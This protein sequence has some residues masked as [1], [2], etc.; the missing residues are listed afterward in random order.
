MY[1]VAS[2]LCLASR[3]KHKISPSQANKN[4]EREAEASTRGVKKVSARFDMGSLMALQ[5]YLLGLM[6]LP[7]LT[8]ALSKQLAAHC[9]AL[10]P[11][12]GTF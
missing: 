5:P 1:G 11:R 7:T 9:K 12:Q 4:D 3:R 2:R 10:K 8:C 6:W